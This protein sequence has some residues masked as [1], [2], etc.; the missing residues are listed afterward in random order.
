MAQGHRPGNLNR[1]EDR[2][3]HVVPNCSEVSKMAE[4]KRLKKRICR[5]DGTREDA[6]SAQKRFID[7]IDRNGIKANQ[8]QTGNQGNGESEMIAAI[9]DHQFPFGRLFRALCRKQIT[10]TA[11]ETINRQRGPK[12]PRSAAGPGK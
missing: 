11:A 5:D 3:A 10:M 1:E 7:G 6:E 4:K 9:G 12:S 2:H 8:E